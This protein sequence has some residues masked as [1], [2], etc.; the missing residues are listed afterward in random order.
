MQRTLYALLKVDCT[1]RTAQVGKSI[2]TNLAE[3]N[4]HEEFCHLKGWYRAA[5]ETQARPC[6][7]TMEKLT[8]EHVDLYQLCES[9][10]LQVAVNIVPVDVRDDAPTNREI[11]VAVSEL[12]N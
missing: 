5:T 8:A 2:V 7:Q 4:V 12:T 6:F 9:P 10:G 1:A 11:R 3:G